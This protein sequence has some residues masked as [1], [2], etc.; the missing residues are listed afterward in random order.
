MEFC[1]EFEVALAVFVPRV[2]GEE[3][4]RV[5]QAV[6]A[7]HAQV[8]Q[9]E[10]RAEVLAD[11]AACVAIRQFDAE[12]HAARDNDNLQR[13]DIDHAHLRQQTQAALLRDRN[14]FV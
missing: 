3:V 7:D 14:N 12:A 13:F 10:E 2:R 9:A 4:A 6:R 5:G 1:D 11:V 8:G